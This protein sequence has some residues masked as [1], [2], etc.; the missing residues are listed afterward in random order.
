MSLTVTGFR[1]FNFELF[2]D[3][4]W[5]AIRSPSPSGDIAL[6]PLGSFPLDSLPLDSGGEGSSTPR[7]TLDELSAS[8]GPGN[9][10]V[11]RSILWCRQ[12]VTCR[13]DSPCTEYRSINPTSSSSSMYA[14]IWVGVKSSAGNI[15]I[16][17][18]LLLSRC[19]PASS[20]NTQSP[21]N[22]SRIVGDTS[23]ICSDV[24]NS[25]LIVRMRAT[26]IPSVCG[27]CVRAKKQA[28]PSGNR[29]QA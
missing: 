27:V 9:R 8:S 6:D 13:Y 1:R 20:Q 17:N 16:F 4:E 11:G 18:R 24:K 7:R 21:T 23:A 22:N 28:P 10:T 25:G 15:S 12:P 3:V 19:R 26:S 2:E 5:F 29:Q 14:P